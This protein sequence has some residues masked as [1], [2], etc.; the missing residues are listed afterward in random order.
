MTSFLL[1]QLF[2]LC[3]TV[4]SLSL[5]FILII[6]YYLY[7]FPSTHYF[8]ILYSFSRAYI[9]T[10]IILPSWQRSG[11]WMRYLLCSFFCVNVCFASTQGWGTVTGHYYFT[12]CLHCLWFS[13]L[14][15]LSESSSI[16]EP[17]WDSGPLRRRASLLVYYLSQILLKY[18][19]YLFIVWNV[20]VQCSFLKDTSRSTNCSHNLWYGQLWSLFLW[21]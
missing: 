19:I 1:L 14:S 20:F 11:S 7:L 17:L 9:Q 12:L 13:L 2:R 18:T 8:V 6:L 15:L 5:G 3:Y 10:N 21:R 4:S 16:S